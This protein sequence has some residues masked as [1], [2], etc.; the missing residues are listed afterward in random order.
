MSIQWKPQARRSVLVRLACQ[1][2]SFRAFRS[3]TAMP[4]R[5]ATKST[6]ATPQW[7]K[8]SSPASPRSEIPFCK[9]VVSDW[10]IRVGRWGA[11]CC[12]R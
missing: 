7:R 1:A 6:S 2:W 8:R 10:T 5:T 4:G 11:S 9:M 3:F 12:A